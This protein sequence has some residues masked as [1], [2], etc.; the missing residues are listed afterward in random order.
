MLLPL[1]RSTPSVAV[2]NTVQDRTTRSQ[3]RRLAHSTLPHLGPYAPV[4]E[5]NGNGPNGQ[6]LPGTKGP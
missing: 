5:S 6:D 1:H 4:L 3:E 2:C